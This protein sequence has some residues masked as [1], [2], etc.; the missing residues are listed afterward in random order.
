M[1]DVPVPEAWVGCASGGCKEGEQGSVIL[2]ALLS[3]KPGGR[4]AISLSL[5]QKTR[6]EEN[7][8]MKNLDL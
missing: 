7:V 8:C 5:R 6:I 3:S 4:L 2:V 1:V